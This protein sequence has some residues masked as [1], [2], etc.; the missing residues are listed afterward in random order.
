MQLNGA[1][2]FKVSEAQAAI[3][4]VDPA[5]AGAANGGL[6]QALRGSARAPRKGKEEAAA[7]ATA[8]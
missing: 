6:D 8:Q 1:A 4:L 3:D 2:H 5:K 7:Q